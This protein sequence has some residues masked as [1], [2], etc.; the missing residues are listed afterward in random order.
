MQ[1]KAKYN[2][3]VV[4]VGAVGEEMLKV[5]RRRK[6]PIGEL[7]VLAR[8]SREIALG[9]VKYQVREIKP[10]EFD[11]VDIALFAGTEGEK[12]AAV[13]YAKEANNRGAVVI[14]NGAD[15]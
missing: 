9:G 7:K 8:S 6:L 1:K 15:F 4:G 5:L 3:A 10:E 14:D 11:S 12:G 13:T 2:V